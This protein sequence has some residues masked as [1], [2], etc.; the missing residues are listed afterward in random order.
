[1]Y[2]IRQP[3]SLCVLC[4]PCPAPLPEIQNDDVE[5]RLQEVSAVTEKMKTTLG[6]AVGTLFCDDPRLMSEIN[7][8][9][10]L[11]GR[12]PGQLEDWIYYAAFEG[13]RQV[14]AG[15]RA[16]HP[17]INLWSLVRPPPRSRNPQKFLEEVTK[18]VGYAAGVC[19]VQNIFKRVPKLDNPTQ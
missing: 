2:L 12:S 11:L 3:A 1:M 19:P 6:V 13:A 4:S 17:N 15:V 14:C 7:T 10:D 18:E 16:H 9:L 8:I 5:A